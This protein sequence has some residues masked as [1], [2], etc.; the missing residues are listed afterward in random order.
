MATSFLKLYATIRI[1]Q[2]YRLFAEV[3][4]GYL[5]ILGLIGFVLV[6]AFM[7]S[8]YKNQLWAWGLLP[9][10]LCSGWHFK[11]LDY[12]FL[13]H[14]NFY[15]PAIYLIDYLLLSFPIFILIAY[16]QNWK[17][18]VIG[19]IALI[20][21]VHI[22]AKKQEDKK[23]TL[24]FRFIPI[25]LFEWKVGFRQGGWILIP[26]YIFSILGIHFEGTVLLYSLVS[27]ITI[28]SFY[29]Y[30]EPKEWI[31]G[32]HFLRKK[33]IHHLG[34]WTFC[35]TPLLVLHILVHPTI[36]YL[37]LI[38][39]YFSVMTISFAIV[40]KYTHWIP[41]RGRLNS[42]TTISVFIGMMLIVF[43]SPACILAILYYYRKAKNNTFLK[44]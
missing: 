40:Y 21:L 34:I 1:K 18:V 7:E 3:G 11:R 2:I 10:A 24:N 26:F 43:T 4:L 29:D 22:P 33:L 31:K 44:C 41:N 12:S 28:S 25:W 36:W 23:H 20:A 14:L 5:I 35:L 6:L 9:A 32:K 42:A 13:K 19:L 8:L 16:F 30:C 38:A 27:T 17:T 37:S 39:W 15:K